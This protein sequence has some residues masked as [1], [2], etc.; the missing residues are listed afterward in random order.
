MGSLEVSI[1][2]QELPKVTDDDMEEMATHCKLLRRILQ[3]S[4]A[5]QNIPP[6]RAQHVKSLSLQIGHIY[7]SLP[8]ISEWGQQKSKDGG[9]GTCEI[10]ALSWIM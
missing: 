4:N 5:N 2:P 10:E 1:A 9:W 3:E 8:S 7:P 6:S